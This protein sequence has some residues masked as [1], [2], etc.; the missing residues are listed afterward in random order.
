MPSP[1]V[2]TEHLGIVRGEAGG[3]QAELHLEPRAEHLNSLGAT[4]GGV[5][6]TLMDAAMA[7]SARSLQEGSSVVTVELKTSFLR[8]ARGGLRAEGRTLHRGASL[9]F[10]EATVYD[11]AGRCCAR[12]SG[13][14][15]YVR[16]R[17]GPAFPAPN[18]S[19]T[20]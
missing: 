2:F 19:C 5:V 11:P 18:D 9:A 13:T 6:V 17:T 14:F 10:C 8:P 1:S 12:A 7:A 15:K 16:R 3:G 20:D 4:H